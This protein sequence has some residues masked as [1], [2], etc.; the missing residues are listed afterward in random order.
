M[1]FLSARVLPVS[2]GQPGAFPCRALSGSGGGSRPRSTARAGGCVPA[3][4]AVVLMEKG[5]R[6]RDKAA[7]AVACWLC[8]CGHWRLALL[9]WKVA[10]SL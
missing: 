7:D 9:V 4:I 2:R 5:K 6:R 1:S 10:G 3:R 8:E